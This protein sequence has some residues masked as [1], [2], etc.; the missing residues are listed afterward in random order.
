MQKKEKKGKYFPR[1]QKCNENGILGPFLDNIFDRNVTEFLYKNG[2]T[3]SVYKTY[4]ILPNTIYA[5]QHKVQA[6]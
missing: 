5:S 6:I 2:L 3:N 4:P 1:C